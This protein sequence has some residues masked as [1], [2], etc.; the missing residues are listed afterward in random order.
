[1]NSRICAAAAQYAPTLDYGANTRLLARAAEEARRA[2]ASLLVCPEYASGFAPEQGEWMR[3]VA[4]P[5]DGEFVSVVRELAREYELTVVA[6]ML[7]APEGASESRPFNTVFAM[8]PDG[9]VAAQYRKVHLYDAFGSSESKWVAPGQPEQAAAVF[10][11]GGFRVGL[12]TCYDLRFPESSR[13]LI[14]AGATVLA[15]PAQW[16]PG[17]LK[18]AH[19]QTLLSARAIENISYVVAADQPAPNAVGH[20]SILDPRGV[21][22]ASVGADAGIAVAWLSDDGLAAAREQNPALR[23]RQYRVDLSRPASVT[24]KT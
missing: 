11:L 3:A 10:E 15:I 23:V 13:R 5:F 9:E 1:M 4:Q 20:S 19:W 16:A 21:V 2:G 8:G 22:L 18:E 17:P 14:D 24:D 12:Q 7:E 6:G